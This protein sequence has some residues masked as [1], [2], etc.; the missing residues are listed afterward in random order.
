M[1]PKKRKASRPASSSP[2]TKRKHG[3]DKAAD[4]PDVVGGMNGDYRV[5]GTETS[6][7]FKSFTIPT[8]NGK[9]IPC[10]TRGDLPSSTDTVLVFTHGAGGGIENPATKLF[11]EGY[12]GVSSVLL[13][14]G[15][16][17]LQNRVKSFEAVVR[18]HQET[19]PDT[20]LAVGGRSMGARAAAMV[21]QEHDEIKKLV[22]VSYPLTSPKGD[23][24]DQILLDLPKEKEVL[25]VIGSN[26]AMCNIKELNKVREKMTARNQLVIVEGGDHGMSLSLGLKGHEKEVAIEQQRR[27][28]GKVA[29]KW[30]GGLGAV[31]L[32]LVWESASGDD[33][34]DDQD[35]KPKK[36]RNNKRNKKAD[37]AKVVATKN[38][39]DE[40]TLSRK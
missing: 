22:L 20:P 35:K 8:E 40:R 6:D 21:A 17:N 19:H 38:K 13:F 11:A 15:T 37:G 9:V 30:V 3:E 25:F 36:K 23:V 5:T 29:A 18:F 7:D 28:S 33:A 2:P 26:D 39:D 31:P 12:A 24:R 10:Q 1:P 16:M 34:G 14:Q 27:N 4:I 32:H